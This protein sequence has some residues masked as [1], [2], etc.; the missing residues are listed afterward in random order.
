VSENITFFIATSDDEAAAV[1]TQGPN[2]SLP[3]V[4][5]AYFDADDAIVMWKELLTGEVHD[6]SASGEWPRLVAP[7]V[8]DGSAVFA[9]S[10]ELTAALARAESPRLRRVARVWSADVLRDGGDID[11]DAALGIVTSVAE[12]ACKAI[13]SGHGVYCWV[14]C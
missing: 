8:N 7:W 10:D 9:M 6:A 12:L 14:G 4:S 3:A 5:G 13:H 11:A 1:R 2:P